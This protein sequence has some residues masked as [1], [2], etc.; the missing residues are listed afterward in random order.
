MDAPTHQLTFEQRD[1]FAG[2]QVPKNTAIVVQRKR[3]GLAELPSFA[4]TI[5]TAA[6]MAED[7]S[8]MAWD[9]GNDAVSPH[10]RAI[11]ALVDASKKT[12]GSK[13]DESPL[14]AVAAKYADDDV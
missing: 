13:A 8:K 3:V 4:R 12:E 1:P 5:E 11:A 2:V 6:G 14:T 9:F 7:A 10:T